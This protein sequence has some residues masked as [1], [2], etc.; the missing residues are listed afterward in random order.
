MIRRLSL[1]LVLLTL[2]AACGGAPAAVQPT[3]APTSPPAPTS[4]PAATDAPAAPTPQPT[5]VAPAVVSAADACP[6]GLRLF[7]HELL[8]TEPI[9]IPTSPERI[10]AL[11]MASVELTLLTDKTL[12]ATS[13]WILSELP[14]LEPTFANTLATVEDVGYPANLEKVLA[15]KPDLILAVGGTSVGDTIDVEQALQIA[16]VV[17]ADPLIYNDWKLG[18]QFWSAV[19]NVPDFYQTMEANYMTRVGE[20]QTA[21]GDS[22]SREISVIAT[23]TY[24]VSLWMPDTP[25]GAI[26]ADVGLA[27][28]EAQSLIGDAAVER[29]KASQYVQISEERL[30]LADGDVIFF[31][32]YASS[33]PATAAQESAHVTAF[34][35]KPLWQSLRAVQAGQAFLVPEYWWRSQTYLLA[36]KV[37][38]DLFTHLTDASATTPVLEGQGAAVPA[39]GDSTTL[40]QVPGFPAY[41]PATSLLEVVSRSDTT[42][43]VKHAYGETDIPA[44]PQRIFVSDPATLQIL[45]SLGIT[46]AGS[47]TF[48]PEL[49]V[50]LQE[51]G[52]EVTLLPDLTGEGINLEQL[53]A[54]NPDLILGHAS[55]APGQISAEQYA[56]LSQIAPTVAFTGNPFFY[57]KEATRELG[58]FFG[59]PEQA[60]SVLA[61]Y[62]AK[63]AGYRARAEAAIGDETVTILLLFDEVMWLYSVGGMLE[64]RYVPL[65]PTGWAYREL[66]LAPGPEVAKLAGDQLWAELSLELIPE[67]K[68]DHLVVFPNAYG[69][70]AQGAGL[71]NYFNTPLWQ[72]VPAVQAGHVHVLTADNAIEGYWTTP[73]LIEQFLETVE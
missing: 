49:P 71:D 54:L 19:L 30:D 16:P 50:A 32:T 15:L 31:F 2:L 51:Q 69:G 22:R 44:N 5:V 4:A 42:V 38:D 23:S 58:D 66:G 47:T 46:P 13:N 68:A 73:F 9:C 29:Y 59:V 6:E 70:E 11:D 33:D 14:L 37:L 41:S 21:L 7:D 34:T 56:K 67:L 25:P 64:E 60:E 43:R 40:T 24:G 53:A 20:L 48:T 1:L 8:A 28:P 26:L 10:I 3:A 52:V 55:A 35:Q 72:T 36:N 27:R 57:W 18:T 62:E 12:L 61:D 63:L 17:I 45:L 65:S 39:G